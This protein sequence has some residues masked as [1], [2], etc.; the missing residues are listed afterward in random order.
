MVVLIAALVTAVGTEAKE[1]NIVWH[2]AA[3]LTIEGRG[4]SNTETFYYR[5]PK[6]AKS[7]VTDAV[8]GLGSNTAGMVVRF[9]TDASEIKARWS[10]TSA[11]LAMN[12]MAASGVSGVDLYVK[13]NGNWRWLGVGRPSE[14][15]NEVT[16]VS[17][18]S[19]EKREFALYLPLYNGISKLELGIL[20]GAKIEAAPPRTVKPVVF[21]GTS[22][23][24]GGC[25][26]RPGMAY[27]AIIGRKL[28]MPTINL[29]FSGNG[30]CE[31][32]VA[33]LL[34]E[35]D[36]SVYVIDSLPNMTE[37]TVDERIRYL[38]KALRRE[39]PDTPVILVENV[40]HQNAFIHGDSSNPKNRIL[41][42][43]YKDFAKEWDGGLYY[44]KCAK[45]LGSDGEGTV[46]GV[47]PTDLGFLRMSESL[48]PVIRKALDHASRP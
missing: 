22:I 28:D 33:D 25:A 11:N 38:L 12:H 13:H 17:G 6:S 44:V 8:W 27:P 24:Q 2:D 40:V 19:T 35:L 26:S 46:D 1:D 3:G 23:T 18:L 42:K 43:I 48:T 9:V 16:L 4:W 5:L 10:L 36:P 41:E 34:A 31:H 7:K 20:E 32:E 37:D 47:H 21:Y 29:G 15:T 30:R 39:H 45:L 14:Q